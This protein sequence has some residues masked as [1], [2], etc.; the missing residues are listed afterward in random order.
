MRFADLART[1]A[2]VLPS[3]RERRH[4]LTP[5]ADDSFA[6]FPLEL[7][8]A[9]S[10]VASLLRPVALEAPGQRFLL[11]LSALSGAGGRSAERRV[12]K[13]CVSTCRSWWSP[14]P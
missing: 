7:S 1:I 4:H 14:S 12:G 8:L 6:P 10:R 13:E 11:K 5:P 2:G 3:A 9:D